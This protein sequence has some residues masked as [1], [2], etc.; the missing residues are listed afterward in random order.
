[1]AFGSLEG[2]FLWDNLPSQIDVK[3]ENIKVKTQTAQR[4]GNI[5]I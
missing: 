5:M 3:K 4:A 2:T 1:M